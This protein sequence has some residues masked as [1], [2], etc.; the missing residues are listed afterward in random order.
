MTRLAKFVPLAVSSPP[1][2]LSSTAPL[3]HCSSPPLLYSST[4]PLLH[5]STA[6][7]L[8]YSTAPLLHCSTTPLFHQSTVPPLHHSTASLLHCSTV[9]LHSPGQLAYQC[10][11][12]CKIRWRNCDRI[13][14]TIFTLLPSPLKHSIVFV[15]QHQPCTSE[16]QWTH[17]LT[18]TDGDSQ[19]QIKET[20]ETKQE[21]YSDGTKLNFLS[22]LRL[23]LRLHRTCL[24]LHQD[25]LQFWWY[26]E[27]MNQR[28]LSVYILNV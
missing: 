25:E 22:L 19:D 15:Y 4:T 10:Q 26:S 8:H 14:M 18:E 11:A 5:C 12:G 3:L 28:H 6:P 21:S 9:A 1:L 7:L 20:L 13:T 23:E 24:I 16:A 27:Y 2:L 17:R